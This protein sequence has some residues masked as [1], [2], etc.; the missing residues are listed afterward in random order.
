MTLF[1]SLKNAL[2]SSSPR[3]DKPH[4]YKAPGFARQ[5][6]EELLETRKKAADCDLAQ[7]DFNI[8]LLNARI[9]SEANLASILASSDLP[10]LILHDLMIS[11]NKKTA[12]IDIL[13][14]APKFIL[15]ISTGGLTGHV[16]VDSGGT[17]WRTVTCDGRALIDTM[18]NPVTR[19][20]E[21]L[22]IIRQA[23]SNCIRSELMKA[24][25]HQSFDQYYKSI[26]VAA[27]PESTLDIR[28]A[29][30]SI[31]SQMIRGDQLIDHIRFL[32]ANLHRDNM[33]EKHMYDLAAWF[34]CMHNE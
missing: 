20:K 33:P 18:P 1:G 26:V 23:R 13:I 5:Q 11:A 24:A 16:E 10:L 25:F 6:L 12:Q 30:L 17:F 32:F 7:I 21:D 31:K 19:C 14:I 27:D 3:L 9:R 4:V 15:I 2:F 28:Q 8:S 22:E 29:D 34:L